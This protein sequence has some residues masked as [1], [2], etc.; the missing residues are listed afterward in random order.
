[1]AAGEHATTA[2][3]RAMG[4][5]EGARRAWHTH[6]LLRNIVT[7]AEGNMLE[8]RLQRLYCVRVDRL[9]TTQG[10][11]SAVV[12]PVCRKIGAA[13]SARAGRAGGKAQGRAGRGTWIC[14]TNASSWHRSSC[15]ATS[16][17]AGACIHT[18]RHAHR[19]THTRAHTHIRTQHT[20][21][22]VRIHSTHTHKHT[23]DEIPA[24]QVAPATHTPHTPHSMSRQ[25]PR[26]SQSGERPEQALPQVAQARAGWLD[27]ASC[28]PRHSNFVAPCVAQ[29]FPGI[30]GGGPVW[31]GESMLRRRS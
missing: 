31:R 23:K 12:S 22:C 6:R 21:T 30:E 10:R 19:H 7:Q 29:Y 15:T 5:I 11:P 4:A 1:M 27:R 26:S 17:P 2:R 13:H 18:H 25:V 20:H 28:A 16:R 9:Q 14:S 3:A 8:H 24:S